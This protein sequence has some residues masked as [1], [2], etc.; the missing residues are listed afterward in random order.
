MCGGWAFL[1]LQYRSSLSLCSWFFVVIVSVAEVVASNAKR[2]R[3]G[4]G[5][6]SR[7]ILLRVSLKRKVNDNLDSF[8]YCRQV[9]YSS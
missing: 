4:L 5:L 1:G 3:H 9:Y 8:A 2:D 7:L 6:I